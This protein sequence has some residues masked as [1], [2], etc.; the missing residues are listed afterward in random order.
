MKALILAAG[1][2]TRLYPLTEN[3]PKPLLKIAGRPIINYIVD[4]LEKINGVDE[5]FI[6][7]NAKFFSCFKKW[8]KEIDFKIKVTIVNDGTKSE[9]SRIGAIGDINL[10]IKKEHINDDLLILGGDNL[11]TWGL[12]DFVDYA[13]DKKPALTVG[14]YD[15]KNKAAASR[16]GVAG[17]NRGRRIINFEEKPSLPKSR[18]VAMCLYYFPKEK[19]SL[20]GEY[21]RGIKNLCKNDATG[22]YISWLYDKEPVYGF[23]FKGHWYD[24]GHVD[25]YKTA[26][27]VFTQFL[28]KGKG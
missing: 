28:N 25:A 3:M 8:A 16:Y 10:V 14:L 1:Y 18:L 27:T 23:V 17:I 19:L 7:T 9:K 24:I 22:N 26:D 4:K 21:L 20:T 15:M 5:V 13:L 6:V 12:G 11:F 2:A